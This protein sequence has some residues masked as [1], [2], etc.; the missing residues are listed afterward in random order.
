MAASGYDRTRPQVHLRIG[1]ARLPEG[2][3]GSF[4]HVNPCTGEVAEFQR[5]KTVAML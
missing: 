3:G 5:I 2:S 4:E 1:L